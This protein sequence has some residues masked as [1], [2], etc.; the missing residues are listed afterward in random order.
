V[1]LIKFEILVLGTPRKL[2]SASFQERYVLLGVA[3]LLCSMHEC[4]VDVGRVF[5][6]DLVWVFKK[7]ETLV[8]GTSRKSSGWEYRIFFI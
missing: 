6:R 4:I 5:V 7:F 8:L 3:I 2:V 1:L